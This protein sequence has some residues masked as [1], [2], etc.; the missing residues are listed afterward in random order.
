[1]ATNPPNQAIVI[2]VVRRRPTAPN[3]V[4]A[5]PTRRTGTIH[6]MMLMA[7][8]TRSSSGGR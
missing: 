1:M 7:A 2:T 4:S 8:S 3:Q 6:A 5:V